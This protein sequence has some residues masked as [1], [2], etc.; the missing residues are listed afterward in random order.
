MQIVKEL[1][2]NSNNK[3][4][5]IGSSDGTFLEYFNKNNYTHYGIV[6]AIL[7]SSL[8]K[9]LLALILILIILFLI[10]FPKKLSLGIN[11]FYKYYCPY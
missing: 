8:K 9:A 7:Y 4:L 11:L 2:L 1:K 3:I 6:V 5:E 10:I